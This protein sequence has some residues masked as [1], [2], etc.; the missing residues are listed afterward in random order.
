MST[1]IVGWDIGGAHLKAVALDADGT[2]TTYQQPTPL[3]LGLEH[4]Q[5][6]IEAILARIPDWRTCRHAIT[7]TGELVDLFSDRE[8]GVAAL[9]DAFCQHVPSNAVSVFAGD[10]GF[11]PTNEVRSEHTAHIASANWLATALLAASHAEQA[12]LIDIGSTTT[13]LIVIHQ[14]R[15]EVR[16]RTDT[17]RLRHQELVYTGIARTSLMAEHFATTADV[18]RLTGELPEHADQMPTA[19]G[20]EKSPGASARRLARLLGADA[21]LAPPSDWRTL[22]HYFR[23]QQLHTIQQAVDRQLSRG[24]LDAGAGFIGAGAGRFLVQ[25]LARR[26]D[27]P[28]QDFLDLLPMPRNSDDFDPADCAPAAAVA[29]LL[30]RDS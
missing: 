7:M 14:G 26:L 20:G 16:G 9:I 25:E 30:K 18:Y 1:D 23:H 2:A 21:H 13:D 27:R 8:Q 24:L 17:E 12:L 10:E 15:P 22:A 28:Y 19:D 6:G 5:R 11:L 4:L 29:C 3:W